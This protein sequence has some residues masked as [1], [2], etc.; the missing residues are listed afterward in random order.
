[1]EHACNSCRLQ[2]SSEILWG[3]IVILAISFRPPLGSTR[4]GECVF[5]LAL[6][7]QPPFLSHLK[8]RSSSLEITTL[9][10]T[11]LFFQPDLHRRSTKRSKCVINAFISRLLQH[12]IICCEMS[13]S[14]YWE[15]RVKEIHHTV[16]RVLVFLD[17]YLNKN[18]PKWK[19]NMKQ[20]LLFFAPVILLKNPM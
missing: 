7:S 16:F 3:V 4:R 1:V 14:G 17:V 18:L 12:K 13:E 15:A 10:S 2:S 20:I 5:P 6:F 11:F 19:G 9:P 8:Q